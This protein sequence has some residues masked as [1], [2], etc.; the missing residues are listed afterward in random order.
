MAKFAF[1]PFCEIRHE[2]PRKIVRLPDPLHSSVCYYGHNQLEATLAFDSGQR[3]KPD[4][5]HLG[6]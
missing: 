1:W 6:R 5:L 4:T 2:W 3:R